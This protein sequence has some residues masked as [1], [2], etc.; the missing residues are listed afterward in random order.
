MF[1]YAPASP[2]AA[3]ADCRALYRVRPTG[4]DEAA[5]SGEL[6]RDAALAMVEAVLFAADE[7]LPPRRLAVAAGLKDAAEARRQVQRLRELLETRRQGFQVEE[8]GGGFQLLS[9][10]EFHPWLV[11]MRRG[12]ADLHLSPAA[13]ET[14]T[15]LAYRQPITRADLEGIRGVQSAEVLGQLIEKGLVRITGRDDSLGRPMLYGTT[16]KF[17]QT[18]GLKSLHDLPRADELAGPTKKAE[19][20]E[21]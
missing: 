16:K 3:T 5:A 21:V 8:L 13:R 20:D 14:L 9:R 4:I 18:Y 19:D 1:P 12:G 17:L 2:P 6:G 7:P 11:R 10:P 15:I